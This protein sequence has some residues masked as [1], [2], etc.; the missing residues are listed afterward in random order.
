MKLIGFNVDPDPEPDLWLNPIEINAVRLP[1]PKEFEPH[2]KTVIFTGSH[3]FGVID[4]IDE[5]LRA[6]I[7][8]KLSWEQE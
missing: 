1:L 3:K 2:V 8:V 7:K 5:V 6:L 4:S